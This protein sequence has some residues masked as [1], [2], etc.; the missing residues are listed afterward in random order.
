[1][2]PP[3]SELQADLLARLAAPTQIGVLSELCQVWHQTRLTMDRATLVDV[4][5]D[6]LYVSTALVIDFRAAR[7]AERLAAPAIDGHGIDVK[8]SL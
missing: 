2:A 8:L 1:M 7:A 4:L 5:A 6:L 3:G